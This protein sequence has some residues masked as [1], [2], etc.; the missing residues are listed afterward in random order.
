MVEIKHQGSSALGGAAPAHGGRVAGD[1][2]GAGSRG[3][4]VTGVGQDRRGGPDDL[5]GGTPARENRTRGKRTVE[6]VLRVSQDD[7]GEEFRPWGGGMGRAKAR[8]SSDEGS[9]TL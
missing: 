5:T 4:E 6:G 8:T 7:S 1:E 2:A 9:E 3:F